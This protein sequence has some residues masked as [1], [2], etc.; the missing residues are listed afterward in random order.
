[1]GNKDKKGFIAK[2]KNIF[3]KMLLKNA[4][5]TSPIF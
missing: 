5:L 4:I 2:K 3:G 1:M